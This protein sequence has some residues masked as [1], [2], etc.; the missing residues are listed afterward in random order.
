MHL[1]WR[2]ALYMVW[3]KKKKKLHQY[4]HPSPL[5]YIINPTSTVINSIFKR[6]ICSYLIR[7]KQ[8][9]DN[10]ELF[11]IF[12]SVNYNCIIMKH[13]GIDCSIGFIKQRKFFIFLFYVT[14]IFLSTHFGKS[15]RLMGNFGLNGEVP[16]FTETSNISGGS[17]C[18]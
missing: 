17:S 16:W 6:K 12:C 7:C 9:K 8:A 15:I 18:C 4:I 5:I 13:E 11:Y 3:V 1:Y 2:S 10:H 14:N